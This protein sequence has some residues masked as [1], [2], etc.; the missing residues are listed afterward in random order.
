MFNLISGIMSILTSG[1]C[2]YLGWSWYWAAANFAFGLLNICI[3]L[4]LTS[5]YKD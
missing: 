5:A 1:L 2:I 4:S 3:G